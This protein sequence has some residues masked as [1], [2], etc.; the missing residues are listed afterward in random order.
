LVVHP[1]EGCSS[2]SEGTYTGCALRETAL[3][4]D[5]NSKLQLRSG[6]SF[7]SLFQ[8]PSAGDFQGSLPSLQH[9]QTESQRQEP[10]F[11]LKPSLADLK[12]SNRAG[13]NPPGSWA[14]LGP[15]VVGRKG[16]RAV[17]SPGSGPSALQ[18]TAPKR[19]NF[20]E[21]RTLTGK[22]ANCCCRPSC[23]QGCSEQCHCDSALVQI[24]DPN[25][26]PQ[27]ACCFYWTSRK[28]NKC[29]S[30]SQSSPARNGF[31]TGSATMVTASQSSY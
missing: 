9:F 10:S 1:I 8:P 28:P 25:H 23:T 4:D 29:R 24:L 7:A 13:D 22:S 16:L 11:V 5:A 27:G 26:D 3:G 14:F 31:C 19:G 18:G 2:S 6:R 17:A 30:A 21:S 20:R 15:H 12:L